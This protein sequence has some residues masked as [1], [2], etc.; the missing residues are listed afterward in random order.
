MV[1]YSI[2]KG[3]YSVKQRMLWKREMKKMKAK[4]IAFMKEREEKGKA[5]I[6]KIRG[7]K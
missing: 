5:I 2:G 3:K 7:L 4:D 1:N 6:K